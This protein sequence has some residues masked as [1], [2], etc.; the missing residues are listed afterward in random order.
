MSKHKKAGQRREKHKK[1]GQR[2]TRISGDLQPSILS[3]HRKAAWV[4]AV[5]AIVCVAAAGVFSV[6]FP[7]RTDGKPREIK[8]SPNQMED[9]VLLPVSEPLRTEQ[10]VIALKKEEIKLA[11]N[12]IRDFPNSDEPLVIMANVCYRHGN[13]IEALEFWNKAL[14][15]NPKRADVYRSMALLSMKKGQF[16]EVITQSR[17]ALE[18]EPQIPDVYS[19]IGHALM[20]SGRPKEAIEA[21]EKEIQISPNSGFAYFLLGQ[22]YLQQKEYEKA[23]ENYKTAIKI[24]P[25][26][27]NAYY[28][29]ASVY[30]KLGNRDKAKEYS[31]NFKKLKAEERKSLKGRKIRYDDFV[32]TQK[33][34]AI[35]YINVGRA[36]REKGNLVRAEELLKQAAGHDPGNIVCF[37]ELAT[38]YQVSSQPSKAL[39]MYKKIS[40]I[41]PESPISYLVI[42]ILSAHLKQ[43]DDAEKAFRTMITLAPQKSDGYREL[44]RLYLKTG[45]KFPQAR[46][47][48]AKAVALEAIATNYFVLSWACDANGDTANA[49]PAIKRAIELDPGNQQYLLLYKQIQLRN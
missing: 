35:T 24:N 49:L 42:G 12:L 29:L 25:E 7:L 6:R 8:Q 43:F 1:T 26:Y 48:A 19:N 32:E 37:L 41:E 4:L 5:L 44:A 28:G 22:A 36:Y 16:D 30:A 17:K 46:Q 2:K 27:T 10:D 14:K 23:Q 9:H 45:Q 15:I 20:M 47:L 3:T 40:E 34:A 18:I 38:L 13:V 33:S 11:E 31:E 39:Q 21:L